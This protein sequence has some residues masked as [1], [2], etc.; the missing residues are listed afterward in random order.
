MTLFPIL[1]DHSDNT[2]GSLT[3]Y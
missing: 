2:P 3:N 1:F